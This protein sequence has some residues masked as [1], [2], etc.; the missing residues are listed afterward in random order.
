[1]SRPSFYFRHREQLLSRNIFGW[2]GL[3]GWSFY[4]LIKVGLV[5]F[6]YIE[7]KLL[8]NLALIALLVVPLPYKSLAIFRFILA[9]PAAMALLYAESYLPPFNRLLQQWEQFSA[10][11]WQYMLELAGRVIQVEYLAIL[12]VCWIVYLY[13]ARVL[14][15]TVIAIGGILSIPLFI[16]ST[17]DAAINNTVQTTIPDTIQLQGQV[18]T[19][20]N[21]PNDFLGNFYREQAEIL[22]PIDNQQAP[23]MDILIV[24]ICSLSWDDLALTNLDNHPLFSRVDMILEN[25]NSASSYSGPAALRLLKAHCGHRPHEDLFE[26]EPQCLLETNLAAVGI[27]V[28]LLMNHD[29]EFDNFTS[30]LNEY[31]GVSRSQLDQLSQF[32]VAME[33]FDQ[34]P[35]YE[36]LPILL[37]WMERTSD[38]EISTLGFYNT[39]S[40]HDGNR[41]PGFSGNSLESF[42]VRA[43]NLLDDLLRLDDAIRESGRNILVIIAPEHG[44]AIRGDRMQMPG[45]REIPSPALTHVPVLVTL[46]GEGLE[47]SNQPA[48][49]VDTQTSPIAIST[50]ISRVI[51]QLPFNGGSYDPNAVAESLPRVPWVAENQDVKVMDY[52]NQYILKLG[53]QSWIR[54]PGATK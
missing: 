39:T 20:T 4:F 44:A 18:Q 34:Q 33:G 5:Y 23:D 10:F 51:R 53:N 29:G 52:N 25:Y 32:P 17:N 35:I 48:I 42:D 38:R 11:S 13:L 54:Y 36:D 12:I 30:L 8:F 24:N 1:M 16:T 26:S 45:L 15:M 37:D 6:G 21:N 3:G 31:G 46:Y 27:E 40:L 49:R 2:P 41:L 43:N 9:L 50:I 7:L 14:R 22:I 28:E 19:T 47:K